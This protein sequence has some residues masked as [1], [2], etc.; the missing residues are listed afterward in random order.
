MS[1]NAYEVISLALP[2]YV[3]GIITEQV[4]FAVML[5]ARYNMKNSCQHPSVFCI[6][7]RT[8]HEVQVL[9]E[10]LSSSLFLALFP[11]YFYV[12]GLINQVNLSLA[13]RNRKYVDNIRYKS[14]ATIQ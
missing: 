10:Q 7:R 13:N 1:M 9:N 12:L 11:Y 8:H 4:I 5:R 3:L 2:P 6:R 14:K